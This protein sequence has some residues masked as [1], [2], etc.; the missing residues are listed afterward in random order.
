MTDRRQKRRAPSRRIRLGMVGG[1]QGAF[2]GGVH[3]IA[4]RIDDH[5]ELVAG[6]LSSDA[7][8]GRGVR[9]PT[10]GLAAERSY[11]ELSRRWRRPRPSGR[12]ASRRSPSSRRTTCTAP[13][14][15]A[16]LEAGI[17]VICDKPL[18]T[19]LADAQEAGRAVREAAGM[20]LRADPQLHRLSD[21]AAG[22]RDGG[23]RRARRRSASC[24]SN[25]AQ[26]WLTDAARGHRPEA[27]RL[28]HRSGAVRRRR[29]ARRHRHPCLSTSPASSPGLRA[30]QR[31]RADL[32]TF[33]PGRRL[34]DNAHVLLR[35]K[36]GAARHALGEPGGAGQRERAAA[37]RLRQQGRP[38]MG[39]GGSRT[40]C[41]FTPLRRAAAR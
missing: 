16:F 30:R 1:G 22:A 21:G 32:T 37:A 36:G 31:S 20:R 34:D 7:G 14:A 39:A 15:E 11:G 40:S 33:V 4:A 25:I 28:A 18:T 24:R 41:W 5:Y 8:A 35:F 2:I 3:R 27:G 13:V 29:L 10:L 9:A 17:H 12:T 23:R 6:A 19:T 38:R 26:D